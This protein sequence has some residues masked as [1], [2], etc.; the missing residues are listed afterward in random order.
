M[1]LPAICILEK[2]NG[3]ANSGGYGGN[4]TYLCIATKQQNAPS[5][6]SVLASLVSIFLMWFIWFRNVSKK[7]YRDTT[8][9]RPLTNNHEY[10]SPSEQQHYDVKYS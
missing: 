1:H 3:S 4:K 5:C 7:K 8:E 9:Q 10:P 2:T 6:W